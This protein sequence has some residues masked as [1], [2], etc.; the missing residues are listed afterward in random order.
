MQRCS[1]LQVRACI[2][3]LVGG[4]NFC[5]CLSVTCTP[6]SFASFGLAIS[7]VELHQDIADI[8][9]SRTLLTPIKSLLQELQPQLDICLVGSLATIPVHHWHPACCFQLDLEFGRASKSSPDCHC[10]SLQPAKVILPSVFDTQYC[11]FH[12]E[13]CW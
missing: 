9:K 8:N 1:N 13:S 6:C 10:R 7:D 11:T 4:F 3:C 5:D 2:C 12:L